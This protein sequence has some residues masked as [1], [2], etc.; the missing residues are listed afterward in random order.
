[1]HKPVNGFIDVVYIRFFIGL[2]LLSVVPNDIVLLNFNAD[3]NFYFLTDVDPF[4]PLE[5]FFGF[6][7]R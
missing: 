5:K 1:V 6:F 2:K 3:Y 7:L 4:P